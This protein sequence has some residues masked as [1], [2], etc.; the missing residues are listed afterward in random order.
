[1]GVDYLQK[2]RSSDTGQ[3]QLTAHLILLFV[4]LIGR[5]IHII[6]E[7]ISRLQSQK[8]ILQKQKSQ[9]QSLYD[10]LAGMATG[11]RSDNL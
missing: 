1:M 2:K 3:P 5:L 10:K 7:I 4:I 6:P 8:N 9:F 11:I